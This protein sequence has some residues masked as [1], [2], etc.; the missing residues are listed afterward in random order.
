MSGLQILIALAVMAL[1][2]LFPGSRHF[3]WENVLS[4]GFLAV[5]LVVIGFALRFRVSHDPGVSLDDVMDAL[6]LQEDHHR[7]LFLNGLL[8]YLAFLGL[9]FGGICIFLGLRGILW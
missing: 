3:D 2:F 5:L 9:M 7:Y 4:F 8:I 1:I 6:D